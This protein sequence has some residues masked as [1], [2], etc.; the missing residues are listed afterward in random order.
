MDTVNLDFR[1]QHVSS[2]YSSSNLSYFCIVSHFKDLNGLCCL[3]RVGFC[4]PSLSPGAVAR[5][6]G[7][8]LIMRSY[9]VLE[10]LTHWYHVFGSTPSPRH[11]FRS[12]CDSI[13]TPHL[14]FMD[15]FKPTGSTS[16]TRLHTGVW[17]FTGT[18]VTMR[19]YILIETQPPPCPSAPSDSLVTHTGPVHAVATEFTCLS[20]R[21]QLPCHVQKASFCCSRAFDGTASGC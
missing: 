3:C 6:S 5:V 16:V 18:W 15:S 12:S 4:S 2:C 8:H 7:G 11:S 19:G 13:T 17:P 9:L 1:A 14:N 20:S 21:V 10:D